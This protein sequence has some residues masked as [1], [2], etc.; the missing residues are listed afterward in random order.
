M[1]IIY[2]ILLFIILIVLFGF[3]YAID[4]FNLRV[5]Y[6][7]VIILLALTIFNVVLSI[8]YYVKLRNEKGIRGPRGPQGEKG[9]KGNRGV[10]ATSEKCSIDDCRGKI[11]DIVVSNFPEIN[12]KCL[13]NLR[14]CQSPDQREKAEPLIKFIN[15]LTKKCQ[16]TQLPSSEF[17]RKIRPQLELLK[18]NGHTS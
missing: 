11:M 5:C 2:S 9:M 16:T 18:S 3:S 8:K 10:C 17:F 12:S 6:W 7:M 13:D 15:E 14:E 1:S 4:D